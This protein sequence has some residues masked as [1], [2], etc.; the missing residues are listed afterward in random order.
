MAPF[1]GWASI[2]SRLEPLR[3]G[4]LL[5]TT[6]TPEISCAHFTN[7]WGIADILE[8]IFNVLSTGLQSFLFFISDSK[9]S[10]ELNV[11][12][13]SHV[14]RVCYVCYSELSS[15]FVISKGIRLLVLLVP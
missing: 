10:N 12:C 1:Y 8:D 14:T 11:V 5:F 15:H 4:S 6:K 7:F 2:A 3:G 9:R 13:W